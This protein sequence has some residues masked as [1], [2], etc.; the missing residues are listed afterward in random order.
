MVRFIEKYTSHSAPNESTLR[1]NY[2][3]RLYTEI[4]ENIRSKAAGKHIWVSLDETTDAEQ[5]KIANFIFGML[6]DDNER[7]KSYLVHV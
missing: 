7:G 5:R 1:C 2:V 3:P 6:D 4:I